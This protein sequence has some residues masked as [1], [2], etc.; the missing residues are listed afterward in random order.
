[1][2]KNTHRIVAG[3]IGVALMAALA[4]CSSAAGGTA[5]ATGGKLAMPTSPVTLNL[6]DVSGDTVVAQPMIEAYMKKYPQYL[7]NVNFST[8]DAT[9]IASKLKA[10][11]AAGVSQIDMVL[12]GND[13]LGAGIQQGL[14]TKLFPAYDAQLGGSVAS[15][16]P[17]AKTLFDLAN[18][19]AVV[20]DFGNYGPLVEYL[21]G[22]VATPPT[23]PAELLA[24]AKAHPGQFEYA[25]PANSGPGRA[26]V[27]GLPYLLGDK[28][29]LDPVK[30]WSKTWAYLKQLGQYIDFY[31][32]GTTATMNDL[33]N[34]S[35]SLI[36]TS[37]GWDINARAIGTVPKGAKIGSFT[38]T[39]WIMDSNYV[40]VPKG[41]SPDK[42]AVVLDLIKWMLTPTQQARAYDDGY[43]YPGPSVKGVTPSMAPAASQAVLKNFGR[44]EYP[45]LLAKYPAVAPLSAQ[46]LG[47]M[48]TM[49]DQQIGAQK[50]KN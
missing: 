10:Q 40:A 24:W 39:S 33:A 6:V 20:N 38:G 15:Y 26:F 1:M 34:G 30:G 23:T 27:Q 44:P 22:T 8:G 41:I 16:Q 25:I 17:G 31:P 29:P 48:F 14:W 42:L 18:G 5:A 4:G 35:R 13:A 28:D 45:A 12:T 21:P 3:A 36:A 50:T 46:N 43:M 11:Q 47:V 2:S 32:S 19:Y 9:Q 49:W 7:A 37:A